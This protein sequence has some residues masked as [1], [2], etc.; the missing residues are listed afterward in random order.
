M[1]N[2]ITLPIPLGAVNPL[3]PPAPAVAA[4]A[5]R[6]RTYRELLSNADNSPAPGSR[7]VEYLQGYGFDGGTTY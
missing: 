1:N 4:I 7:I 3:A 2:E 6:P 5:A